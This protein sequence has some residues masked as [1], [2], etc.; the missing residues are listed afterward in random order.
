MT[1]LFTREGGAPSGPVFEIAPGRFA[2]TYV[3]PCHR[4]GGRGGSDAWKFTGWT[5]F[6]CSGT[7]K[8]AAKTVRLYTAEELAKLDATRAKKRAAKAAKEA[9]KAAAAKIEREAA[10]AP[11]LAEHA[12]L[13]ASAEP[14]LEKSEFLASVIGKAR[15][16]GYLSEKAIAAIERTVAGFAAAAARP[17]SEWIGEIGER[18]ELPVTVERVSEF[19]RPC[20]ARA[21]TEVVA[22]TKMRTATGA[23]LTVMSPAFWPKKGESFTIRGTVKKHGA[24]KE[25]R[26]TVLSRAVIVGEVTEEGAA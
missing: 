21:G 17:A 10:L 13:F 4:C 8:E 15:E 6:R 26:E 5:C 14:F 11:F 16:T 1:E 12:A 20:F 22:V 3:A 9:E 23:I 25:I 18:I 7:C 24:F 2:F 19:E